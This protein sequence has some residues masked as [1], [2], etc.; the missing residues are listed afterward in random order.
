MRFTPIIRSAIT[1]AVI[2]NAVPTFA[3]EFIRYGSANTYNSSS[4]RAAFPQAWGQYGS[5]QQHNPVFT[6]PS[7]APTFLTS[8]ISTVAPLTGDEMRR[9]DVAAKYY[10]ADGRM[11]WATTAA[12]WVGNVVGVSMAQGII[13]ATTS[14]R[15]V[16]ALDAQSGLAIWRKELVGVAGMG[17]PLALTLGGKLRIIVTAGDADFNGNNVIRAAQLNEH[18]R[19]AEFT[20]V[21]CLDALT[22]S[23]VWRF[24]TKGNVRPTPL[25]INGYLYVVSGDGFLYVLDATTG[26][27]VSSFANPG[28]GQ[29]G[30]SSPNWYNTTDGRT[31]IYYGTLSPR[32]ILAVDVTN[33]AAPVLAWTYSPPGAASNAP[34]DVSVAVDPATGLLTTSIFTNVGTSAAPIFDERVVAL[35]ATTGQVVWSVF[36]GQ[37]PTMDGFKSANPMI[38]NGVVYTGNPLNATVQ[39]FDLLTG[40]LLWSTPIPSTDPDRRNAPRAA[41]TLVD[42]KLIFPVAQHI[43]TF[44]AATGALLNDYYLPVSYVAYGLNQ[45]VVIG[46]IAYISSVSGYVY[47]Y[48]V[49]TITTQA[50]PSPGVAPPLPLK[51]AEY[52]NSGNAPSS[53][54]NFPS[55]WLSYAGGPGHNSYLSSG[56][57]LSSKWS[58]S[59]LFALSLSG[60]AQDEA[61]FGKEIASQM[62]HFSF[63]VGS[64]VSPVKGILYS[65]AGN[66]TVTAHNATN[67]KLIW[68]FR[69]NNHNFGQPLVTSNAVIVA[70]GNVALNLGQYTNFTKRSSQTRVGTGYMYIHALDPKNGNEKWSFYSGQGTMS[71]TPLYYNGNLYWVDGQSQMWAISA[72]TGQPVAPFMDVNGFPLLN[73]GGGFNS[74][75]SANLYTDTA[76]RKLMVVGMAMPNRMVAVDLATATVAWT[77][78]LSAF[79]VNLVGFAAA[80]PAVDQTNGL[81]VSS[82]V[83]NVDNL[84]NTA[85]VLVFALNGTT[86]DL[87]WSQS[88]D[89]G[90]VPSGFVSPTP[91]VTNNK[92]YISNPT[93]NQVVVLDAL[94]GAVTW[95][96]TVAAVGGNY[97]WAPPTLVGTSKLIVPVGGNLLTFDATTGAL[98]KTYAIG[99]GHTFNHVTVIGKTVYVG[100]S[101]GWVLGIPLSNVTG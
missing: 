2:L 11:A 28:E 53:S 52:Y 56:P 18:D 83:I 39:A 63:G 89:V 79:A 62:T 99:G 98:L 34:G 91:M 74:T 47:A 84:L 29:V 26:A 35:N 51:T 20:A 69:T 44:D 25:F 45:P 46:N 96:T 1:M 60:T 40:T 50:A 41:P 22:G 88:M 57:S 3:Q 42:G 94:T 9:V 72:S 7:G 49:S 75:S 30:L 16:Y 78:P 77:Q 4:A 90:S 19:G 71:M 15:E 31:L 67:G 32:N 85:Q 95:K 97:S 82:A 64:G 13:F 54:S 68:R 17:Q 10:P 73:L 12:Q 21:Y 38:S 37:G 70:G 81:I 24:D 100:N 58:S 8:G 36:S 5:N 87:V 23:Q 14:R 80:S 59:L 76:G 55:T 101:F 33:P 6:V 65:S 27:Q 86:G 61:L 43:Y 66:R 93:A 92:V 48:P